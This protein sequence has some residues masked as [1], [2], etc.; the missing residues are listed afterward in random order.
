MHGVDHIVDA[1]D[2][3]NTMKHKK[4]S[5]RIL[6]TMFN[7]ERTA[8]RVIHK[9]MVDKYQGMLFDTVIDYD[10]KLQEAQIMH[11]PVAQYDPNS[12]AAIQYMQLA[13]EVIGIDG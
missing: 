12:P 10:P 3:I 11:C 1:I 6:F 4:I 13:K 5:R 2:T 8:A 7:P 9:R